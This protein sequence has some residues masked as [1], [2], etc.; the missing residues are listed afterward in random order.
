MAKTR[1]AMKLTPELK[2]LI[3][4]ASYGALNRCLELAS[5]G[6]P[7]FEGETA[8]YWAKRSRETREKLGQ[9]NKRNAH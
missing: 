5:P 4:R 8:D 3:D 6:D 7:F 2:A 9:D 1:K